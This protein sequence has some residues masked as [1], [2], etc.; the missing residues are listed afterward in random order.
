MP[1][2]RL[3]KIFSLPLDNRAQLFKAHF[4][5]IPGKVEI[6]IVIYLQLKENFSEDK[7]LG[8]RNL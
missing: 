7:G 5:A 8:K 6:L 4:N 1:V 3:H 2:K